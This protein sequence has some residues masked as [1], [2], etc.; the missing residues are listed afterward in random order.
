MVIGALNKIHYGVKAV[1]KIVLIT[2]HKEM[3][4]D[5]KDQIIITIKIT[6]EERED[7]LAIDENLLMYYLIIMC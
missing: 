3:V 4:R 2:A 6:I 5:F 1:A 7:F